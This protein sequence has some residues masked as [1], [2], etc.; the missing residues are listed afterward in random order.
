MALPIHITNR[1]RRKKNCYIDIHII[2]SFPPSCIN[3]GE[4]GEPKTADYGGCTRGRLSGQQQKNATRQLFETMDENEEIGIRTRRV[5]ELIAS[6]IM[7]MGEPDIEK[8]QKMAYW[9][10]N[11][12]GIIPKSDNDKDKDK[13]SKN[14]SKNKD[15]NAEDIAVTEATEDVM[16]AD[17]K[18]EQ[19]SDPAEGTDEKEVM[20]FISRAQAKALAEIAIKDFKNAA[21]APGKETKEAL[22]AALTS[23][24]SIDIALFGRMSASAPEFTVDGAVCVANA[25]T[26][27][28][29]ESGYDYFICNDD[30]AETKGAG[31]I[32]VKQFNT[33][34]LY[35]FTTLNLGQLIDTLGISAAKKAAAIYV[36]CYAKATFEGSI[37]NYGNFNF[38]SLVHVTIREDSPH[39]FSNAF[40][41]PVRSKEGYI[42]PSI[43]ALSHFID[44]YYANIADEP[45]YSWTAT[46]SD[47]FE[48]GKRIKLTKLRETIAAA[49]EDLEA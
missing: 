28:K 31:H 16:P 18:T 5:C 43:K 49:L 2:Q 20:F 30:L 29:C 8:A 34:T 37:H 46:T 41:A 17:I 36:E 13:K 24:P 10:M 23:K 6:Y 35:R 32:G 42:E 12:C 19:A 14:K 4:L 25:I 33:P 1:R 22:R 3:R 27:H 11:G 44:K 48:Y 39:N 15:N 45:K 7:E 47:N 38:P 9:A 40:E 26:T 21:T